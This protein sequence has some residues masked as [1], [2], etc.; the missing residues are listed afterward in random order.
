VSYPGIY[1][2]A[3]LPYSYALIVPCSLV[4]I[5]IL[6]ELS[7][8]DRIQRIGSLSLGMGIL[9]LGYDLFAFFGP[10]AILILVA[11]RKFLM[12]VAVIPLLVLPS[13]IWDQIL[14]RVFHVP[15]SNSN[16]SVYSIIIQS[17]LRRPDWH[18]W[19]LLLRD[20]P[21]VT[22]ETFFYSNF[23]FLPAFFA[24]LVVIGFI[25]CRN[26]FAL[27]ERSLLAAGLALYL[28]LDLAPP[29]PGLQ[30]RG[31]WIPRIYQPLFVAFL[32]FCS[33]HVIAYWQDSGRAMKVAVCSL[34]IVVLIG[35]FRVSLGPILH[36]HFASHIYYHFYKHSPSETMY[37]MLTKYGRRPLG[38]CRSS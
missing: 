32:T 14:L 38:F 35:N 13:V 5:V 9:F 17:Y 21:K 26:R 2:W 25:T 3:G 10:A 23:L 30:M 1:Y 11:R 22:W 7:E 4:G 31:M 16:T 37:N 27:V 34:V 6:W 19:W 18:Q 36:D 15:F 33:R 8:E 28:F 20:F 29:Y 12:S 24:V